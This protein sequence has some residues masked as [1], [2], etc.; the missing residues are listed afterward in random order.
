MTIGFIGAGKVGTTLG[1]YFK[2][3]GQEIAGF[4]SLTAE[5]A[6]W[7]AQFTDSKVYENL[8][9]MI[10]DSDMLMFTVP[11]GMI[12][13]VWEEAKPYVSQKILCHCSGLHSSDIFSDRESTQSVG[14]SMHPL[15][16]ISSK[17]HM[18]KDMEHVLFTIEGDRSQIQ[19]IQDWLVGMG[20]PVQLVDS[21]NKAKYHA[22]ASLASNHMT[23]IFAMAQQCF[24]E[25]G[26]T[27]RQAT[28][29]L[30]RL[31]KGNLDHIRQQGC[32]DSLTGPIERNDTQTVKKHLEVLPADI[33]RAYKENAKVLVKLAKEKYPGRDY[34]EMFHLLD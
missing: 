23:A 29:E 27:T 26:F 15:C 2:E 8:Q 12:Q 7:A 34:F 3:K 11:D 17:E 28:E 30:Y 4:Y 33:K 21:T 13:K 31:A 5:S 9:D 25:C 20:N 16:A 22:A 14:Y 24:M 1:K 10:Q 19:M 32:V 18:W 6:R